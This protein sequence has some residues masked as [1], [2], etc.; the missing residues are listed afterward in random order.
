MSFHQLLPAIEGFVDPIITNRFNTSMEI[1]RNALTMRRGWA[2]GAGQFDPRR[3]YYREC[4]F[5]ESSLVSVDKLY[6]LYRREAIARRVIEVWPKECWQV[7]PEVTD[8]ED[9]KTTTPFQEAIANLNKTLATEPGYLKQK[10]SNLFFEYLYRADVQQGIGRYGVI[11]LGINDKKLLSEPADF[12]PSN[13]SKY[14]LKYMRVFSEKV[15][16]VSRV[17]G[18]RFSPRFGQPIEYQLTFTDPNDSFAAEAVGESS[19]SQTVHWTRVIHLADNV[20]S[21]NVVG[22]PRL[23]PVLNNVLNLIKLYGGSAEMYWLGALMGVSF[24]THPQMGGDVVI[25]FNRTKDQIEQYFNGLQRYLLNVGLDAKSLAPSVVSPKEQIEVQ[26]E[27]ICVCLGIP[28]P[29]FKGYEIG[30]QASTNNDSDHND[31]VTARQNGTLTPRLV[32][33]TIDRLINLSI[34]PIPSNGSYT[35]KWPSI[36]NQSDSDK[37]DVGAK[38]TQAF[39]EYANSPMKEFVTPID[40]LVR[41]EGM[42]EKEANMVVAR[43]RMEQQQIAMGKPTDPSPLLGMVGGIDGMINLFKSFSLGEISRETLKQT[44]IL[45][46]KIDEAKAEMLIAD[47]AATP[48]TPALPTPTP[49]KPPTSPSLQDVAIKPS[50]LTP[51]DGEQEEVIPSPVIT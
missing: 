23:L 37:A 2:D 31:R 41:Y 22:E 18:D 34:L 46:F 33:P 6:D 44:L 28:V 29:V 20:G 49:N 13:T 7:Q 14:E 10:E 51:E 50:P 42:D 27:A 1:V 3:D 19:M 24:Q 47:S 4:G 30:E 38:R 5:P 32:A 43:A 16:Q 48:T 26:I 39:V 35:T 25:D 45:F 9:T 15:A 17:D 8:S 12:L 36:K 21:S 11:L 40:Y